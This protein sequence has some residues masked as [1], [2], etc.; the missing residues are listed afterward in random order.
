MNTRRTE[1]L[2]EISSALGI[3]QSLVTQTRYKDKEREREKAGPQ[4]LGERGGGENQICY[5]EFKRSTS[6]SVQGEFS[7]A[8]GIQA[9]GIQDVIITRAR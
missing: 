6:D 9:R 5:T 3:T 1:L 4:S 8:R 2:S 7:Q